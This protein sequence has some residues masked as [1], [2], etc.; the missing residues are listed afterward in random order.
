MQKKLIAGKEGSLSLYKQV[1]LQGESTNHLYLYGEVGWD[2]TYQR[3]VQALADIPTEE[4]LTVHIHSG[5]GEVFEGFAIY[6]KL[7]ARAGKNTAIVEGMAGSMASVIMCSCSAVEAYP[8]STV[9]IHQ[10]IT[11]IYG[12]AAE[13]RKQA[14]LVDQ[15]SN[16]AIAVYVERTGMTEDDVR[17]AMDA[18]T[19]YTAEEALEAGFVDVIINADPDKEETMADKQTEAEATKLEDEN[20]GTVEMKET[21]PKEKQAEQVFDSAANKTRVL[22]IREV[23]SAHEGHDDLMFECV[24]DTNITVDQAKV[25]LLDSLGK[26]SSKE[27]TE[28]AKVPRVE[29]TANWVESYVGGATEAILAKMKVGE[30]KSDS[31]FAKERHKFQSMSLMEIARYSLQMKSITPLGDRI[32]IVGAA[33]QH[34][35]GDFRKILEDSARK[36]MLQGYMELA[37]HHREL[38]RSVSLQDFKELKMLGLGAFSELEKVDEQGEYKFG[39]L[40][41]FNERLAIATY[42]KQ[43]GIS[44]EAIINDDLNALTEVPRKMGMAVSRMYGNMVAGLLTGDATLARDGQSIFHASRNNTSTDA[45]S[46][47]SFDDAAVAMR[48]QKGEGD[49][50][51][52]AMPSILYCP[53]GLERKVR[54]VLNSQT[55]V[56]ETLAES[57]ATVPNTVPTGLTVIS[58]ARLDQVSGTRW[59][60][61]ANPNVYDTLAI[62]F[63]DG[64]EEPYMETYEVAGR[65]GM[66]YRIR[67]DVGVSALDY[68][69][70]YRGGA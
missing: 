33:F 52:E 38:A 64:R 35:T 14:D 49:V 43:F 57:D 70:I 15:I 25:K 54:T 59:Y 30:V 63:L 8:A 16:M 2:L 46:T 34:G 23:F 50:T 22:A 17:A 41:E 62:G 9:M 3:V 13:L 18:E 27:A 39:T 60:M 20:K 51:V 10:P 4:E 28:L 11:G 32:A 55:H 7:K 66:F 69:G 31:K 40:Q 19:Y 42:G 1:S 47:D 56:G 36:S 45:P 24:A 44:R 5:G 58:D 67:A 26:E 37:S 48:T 12:T 29:T 53:V 6:N 68:K 21:E 61:L 65:D